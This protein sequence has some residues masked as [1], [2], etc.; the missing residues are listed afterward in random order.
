M[1]VVLLVPKVLVVTVVSLGLNYPA[2][3]SALFKWSTLT[4]QVP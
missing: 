2:L 1:P 3:S 4:M